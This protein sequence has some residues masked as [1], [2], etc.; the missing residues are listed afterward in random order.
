MAKRRETRN[1]LLEAAAGLF[2]RRGYHGAGINS[3]IEKAAAPTGSL[4]FHFPGGKQE[5]AAAA[6]DLAGERITAAI[7]H[8]AAR[9]GSAAVRGYLGGL[10]AMLEES[11]WQCGCPIATV[12]LDVASESEQVRASCANAYSS[13]REAIA[14]GLAAA[15]TDRRIADDEALLALAATQGALILARAWQ[16]TEPLDVVGEQLERLIPPL[17][18]HDS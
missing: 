15:G 8:S 1:R 12:T 13:W 14:V 3:V 7:E 2:Q 11:D 17:G 6:V 9:D 18:N 10:A 4:Y 5:L 16:T